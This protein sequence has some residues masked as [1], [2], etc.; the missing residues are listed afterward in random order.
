MA[1]EHTHVVQK[2]APVPFTVADG[3]GIEKGAILKMTT[4]R[5]ASASD[6]AT[7]ILAGISATEK[8]AN[9]GRRTLG[10]ISGPGDEFVARSSGDITVGDA[11]TV[12][13][14][15]ANHIMRMPEATASNSGLKRLGFALQTVT[16]AQQTRYKLDMG[17][18]S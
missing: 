9:D 3:T 11:V 13:A 12:A 10:V 18:T 6:G 15:P 1:N 4:P 17:V 16:D 2:T 5:T 8:I 14:S 7:D